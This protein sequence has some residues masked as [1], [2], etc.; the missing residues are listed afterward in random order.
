[1]IFL[2]H[3]SSKRLKTYVEKIFEL[4]FKGILRLCQFTGMD[5][6]E[7]KLLLTNYE[8]DPLGVVS[9]SWQKS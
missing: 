8:I 1:M 3:K 9:E 7:I 6:S 2:P 5:S 4:I